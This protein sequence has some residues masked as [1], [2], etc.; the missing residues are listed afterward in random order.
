MYLGEE[1][2]THIRGV[3]THLFPLLALSCCLDNIRRCQGQ[4]GS[5]VQESFPLE[6]TESPSPAGTLGLQDTWGGL[7]GAP[8]V[9]FWL[10]G[11]G[12]VVP[13]SHC[14]TLAE[15]QHLFHFLEIPD[16]GSA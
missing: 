1:K 8:V 16:V 7:S 15:K 10:C 6:L 11:S 9:G 2:D 3:A 5:R 14:Q 13:W 4:P 12:S